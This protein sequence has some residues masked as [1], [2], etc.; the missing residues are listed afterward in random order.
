[1][2]RFYSVLVSLAVLLLPSILCAQLAS[3]KDTTESLTVV[4]SGA[5]ATTNPNYSLTWNSSGVGDTSNVAGALNGVTAVV[6]LTGPDSGQTRNISDLVI[7][8]ADTA[9]VTVTVNKKVGSTSYPLL[10]Q[11]L[12]V[13]QTLTWNQRTGVQLSSTTAVGGGTVTAVTG[14][15]G[16]EGGY[17]V[18]QRTTFTF[19]NVSLTVA[20]A[21]QGVGQKIY[22][23]PDGRVFVLGAL[24]TNTFTTTSILA[25]T[26]NTGSSC[27][28]GVGT[29]TQSNLTL[30]TT[31]QDIIPVTTF[32]SSTTINVANAAT[33]A[34]LAAAA[35]FDGTTTAKDL[36]FNI[37]VPTDG[38]LDADATVAVNG[39]VV[40]TWINLGDY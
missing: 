37:S 34:A 28:W 30:A 2:K 18:V 14:M 13:A 9:P 27:R 8:N 6:P 31:E 16:T 7:Y 32:T 25:N 20:N 36:Y 26:L 4:M 22:D 21:V 11:T 33:S 19:T 3:L 1:M 24:G 17:G 15:T 10:K 39:F 29:A 5:V 35:Q 23:F 38:D 40:V 12:A